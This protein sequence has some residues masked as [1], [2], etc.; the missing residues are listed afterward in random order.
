MC[1]QI[2]VAHGRHYDEQLFVVGVAD[3]RVVDLDAGA[4]D[5]RQLPAD[6]NSYPF[7][8]WRRPT[9]ATAPLQS[10]VT[11]RNARLALGR[12]PEE[13]RVDAP[14]VDEHLRWFEPERNRV[15]RQLVGHAVH[16]VGPLEHGP[17]RFAVSVAQE[18]VDSKI[19]PVTTHDDGRV[20]CREE[21]WPLQSPR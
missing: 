18:W 17:Q 16:E 14:G 2:E 10:R 11:V 12:R 15:A 5:L 13:G 7:T 20:D 1:L 8:Q 4:P 3:D 21:I 9:L 19:G 6:A